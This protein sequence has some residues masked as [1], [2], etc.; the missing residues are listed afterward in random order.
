MDLNELR[1]RI[2]KTDDEIIRLVTERMDIA[3]GIAAY[4]MAHG[5]PVLQPAREQ[6]KL[7]DVASKS[8]EDLQDEMQA[9]FRCL[10]EI[11]RSYQNRLNG[12]EVK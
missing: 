2:D 10:F 11:S 8:R 4:K 5:L 7:A 3:A 12:T 6:E 9:L 1:Q